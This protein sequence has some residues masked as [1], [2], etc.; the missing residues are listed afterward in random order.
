[1]AWPQAGQVKDGPGRLCQEGSD[2]SPC[3]PAACERLLRRNYAGSCLVTVSQGG[4]R[5]SPLRCHGK[6]DTSQCCSHSLGAAP[7]RLPP[8]AWGR[9][10]GGDAGEMECWRGAWDPGA[11]RGG[12][13]GLV[14]LRRAGGTSGRASERT[15]CLQGFREHKGSWSG[16][17]ATLAQGRCRSPGPWCSRGPQRRAASK[18]HVTSRVLLGCLPTRWDQ[19]ATQCPRCPGCGETGML[20]QSSALRGCCPPN[21]SLGGCPPGPGDPRR[22]PPPPTPADPSVALARQAGGGGGRP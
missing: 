2:L 3:G 5:D 8:R 19:G 15:R 13:S 20:R 10:S 9:A 18:G 16:G 21:T 11:P 1:M 12:C 22:H 4:H 7:G 17:E 14:L 6:T